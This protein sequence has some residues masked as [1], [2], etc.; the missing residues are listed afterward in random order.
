MRILI[1]GA[2]GL[3]GSHVL[4]MALSNPQVEHVI[5][6]V[7]RTLPEHPR[8]TTPIISFDN[9]DTNTDLWNVDAVICALGT[10]MKLAGTKEAFRKVDYELPLNI[11]TLANEHGCKI[12]ALNSAIGANANSPFFYNRV[13]GELEDSLKNLSFNSLTLVRP[14]PIEGERQQKRMNEQMTTFIL[15]R[16]SPLLPDRWKLN[17]AKNIAQALLDSVINPATGILIIPSNKL[18]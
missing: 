13:K 17:P 4:E 6:P 12:F 2:T 7:R 14:G 1:A 16:I 3:V 8:L 10:T 5:A 18:I 9:L 11:A 15:S